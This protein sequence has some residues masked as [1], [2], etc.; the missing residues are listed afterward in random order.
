MSVIDF[1]GP[2]ELRNIDG[3]SFYRQHHS[4]L[5]GWRCTTDVVQ[6]DETFSE[7]YD[8]ETGFPDWTMIAGSGGKDT[9]T[10]LMPGTSDMTAATFTCAGKSMLGGYGICG[11]RCELR[12]AF[13]GLPAHN[14]VHLEVEVYWLDSWDNEWLYIYADDIPVFAQKKGRAYPAAS[15]SLTTVT[16]VC[17]HKSYQ[18]DHGV[19]DVSFYHSSTSLN[20]RFTSNLNSA[21]SDES[22][23]V[24][25]VK[26]RVG[27]QGTII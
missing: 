8:M 17:G 9:Y 14:F 5:T 12:K 2:G 21:P 18:D 23:G 25:S 19:L 16:Q 10:N 15:S 22:W 27:Q 7:A 13:T 6:T 24:R 4:A 20:L 1:E 3:E 26:V 11:N